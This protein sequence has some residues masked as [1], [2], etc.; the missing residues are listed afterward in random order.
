MNGLNSSSNV[1]KNTFELHGFPRKSLSQSRPVFASI[2]QCRM[3]CDDGGNKKGLR[4]KIANQVK[5]R[6]HIELYNKRLG[7]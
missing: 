4:C 2:P 7:P 3:A 6:Y 1:H 5:F